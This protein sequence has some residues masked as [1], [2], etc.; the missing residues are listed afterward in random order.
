MRL[1]VKGQVATIRHLTRTDVRKANEELLPQVA[2]KKGYYVAEGEWK[3]LGG[4]GEGVGN[5]N[6]EH[7]RLVAGAG[8]EPATFGL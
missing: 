6:A 1:F 5:P 2:E 7:I 8:F 3:L 4:Y